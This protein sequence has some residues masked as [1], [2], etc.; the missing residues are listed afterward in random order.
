MK[1]SVVTFLVLFVHKLQKKGA[2]RDN[3]CDR[4]LMQ[5]VK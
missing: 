1:V 4:I 5:D 3:D 2:K